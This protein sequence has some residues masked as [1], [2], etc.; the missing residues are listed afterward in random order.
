MPVLKL[1]RSKYPV[2]R[3]PKTESLFTLKEVRQAWREARRIYLYPE[4]AR[5]QEYEVM[6]ALRRIGREKRKKK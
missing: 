6:A 5:P 1:D 4:A 3:K 2:K